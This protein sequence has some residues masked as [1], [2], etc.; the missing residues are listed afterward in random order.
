M[1]SLS[2]MPT[3][4]RIWKKKSTE[5]FQSIP[6]IV[7]LFSAMLWIYYAFVSGHM[8]LISINGSVCFME[9]VYI[10]IYL[11]YAQRKAKAYTVKMLLF[12]NVVFFGAILFLTYFLSHGAKRLAILGW[13]CSTFAVCVF[14]APLSIIRQVIR[15]K[16]VEFMPLLL[17]ICLTLNAVA[18]FAYGFSLKD[19]YVA[20][21]NILGFIFGAAQ[22]VLYFVYKN[23]KKVSADEPKVMNEH[24][25]MEFIDMKSK[26]DGPNNSN[27]RN[28]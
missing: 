25:Q 27:E 16:S 9:T 28:C 23:A 26:N 8:L 17:S 7:A 14:A 4:Y 2:P 20:L 12:L 21:P 18:W 24:C 3:F 22:I 13:I 6:Y 5:G 1:V 15:T 10:I 19:Y 11:V